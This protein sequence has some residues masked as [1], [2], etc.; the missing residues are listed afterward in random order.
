MTTIEERQAIRRMSE[1]GY[2]SREIAE[3]LGLTIFTVRKWRQRLKK[4]GL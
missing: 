1:R 4:G 3:A 2:K